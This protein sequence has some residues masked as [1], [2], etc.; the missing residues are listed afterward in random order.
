MAQLKD[1]VVNGA[2]RFI[3]NVFAE[4]IQATTLNAPTTSGGTTYGPGGADY[5]LKSNGSSIY[6]SSGSAGPTGPTGATGNVGPTGP[7]GKTGNTGPTGPTGATGGTGNTGPTGPT[8]STGGTGTRGSRWSSGT[9]VTGTSTTGTKFNTGI[10][11]ALVNDM[12]LNTSTGYVYRCTTAGPTGT[13]T[14]VYVGSIK[15]ATGGTGGTGNTGPTGPTGKTGNTGPTGPT[16]A[17]GGT[18]GTGPTGPTGATGGTGGVGPT[19]PTGKTGNTGPTGPTGATG[20]TGAAGARGSRWNTGTAMTGT[21]TSNTQFSGS[22]ITD[23]LVNDMYLNTSTGYVYRCTVAGNATNARWVY[24]GSIKGATGGAGGT[25]ATGPTGPTG[26][27]GGT[28][29]VGPTGP[30]GATGLTNI[31]YGTCDTAAGTAAKVVACTNYSSLTAGTIVFVKFTNTNSAAVANLTMNVNSKGAKSIKCLRNGSVQNLPDVGY[32][33]ANQVYMFWYDGTQW[34]TVVDYNTNTMVT[35]NAATTAAGAYPVILA[36]ST[37]TTAVSNAVNKT[38]TLTY[39]PSTTKLHTPI[40]EVT[41]ASYGDTLP[42]SGTT[43]QI[44]F[45]SRAGG[46]IDTLLERLQAIENKIYPVGSIYISVNST[47]PSVLF[48]GTWELLPDRFLLG[49]GNLYTNGSMDGETEHTLTV[50][51]IPSHRHAMYQRGSGD[52]GWGY[53]WVSGSGSGKSSGSGEY[54]SG[55]FATGGGAAHNNMPPYLAVYMWKRTA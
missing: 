48:G 44:F 3:G 50:N 29:G 15:G 7:T 38:S 41:T 26:A 37:A 17:T 5:V 45:K 33:R 30:T 25:G 2:S 31:Y 47:D 13:A 19:G 42:S 32:L 34:V 6:W 21:S 9:A 20:G 24:V 39:N 49:A 23:A 1:L 40:L 16:G 4:K 8:G 12:Y 51:E 46:A 54:A 27:T 18:G 14:W 28:G 53:E 55:V 22:G 35:Q 10:T 36:Y 11:D 43:G 52:L